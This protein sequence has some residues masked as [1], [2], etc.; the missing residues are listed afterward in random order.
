MGASAWFFLLTTY[1]PDATT[2]VQVIGLV[3]F[4]AFRG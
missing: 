3:M 4:L 2:P 1:Q